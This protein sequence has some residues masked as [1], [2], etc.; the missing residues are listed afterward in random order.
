M[1]INSIKIYGLN[2]SAFLTS[3]TGIDE[4]VKLLI[5]V[6]VLVYTVVKTWDI[7]REWIKKGK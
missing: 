4:I 5:G 3:L 2:A 7:V 6:A 1:D